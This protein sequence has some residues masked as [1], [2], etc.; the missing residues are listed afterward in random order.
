EHVS[1]VLRGMVTVR[2]KVIDQQGQ[3]ISGAKVYPMFVSR[4]HEPMHAVHVGSMAEF[5][6][7]SDETGVAVCH[8]PI[9]NIHYV[10]IQAEAEGYVRP[11]WVYW[12]PDDRVRGVR[13]GM[14]VSG[15]TVWGDEFEIDL[16]P[17]IVVR[18]TVCDA[19]GRPAAGAS[20][21]AFGRGYGNG[22]YVQGARC[23]ALGEFKIA[24]ASD[25]YYVFIA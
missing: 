22:S 4:L 1:L 9:D 21:G 24:L 17:S 10:P 23:D 11:P 3:G 14:R 20:V 5:Q 15:R 19:E 8:I 2:V 25:L 18:G 7:I 6:T 13:T 16:K 12:I